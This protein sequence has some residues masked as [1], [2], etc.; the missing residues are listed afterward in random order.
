MIESIFL[1]DGRIIIE[2]NWAR[3]LDLGPIRIGLWSNRFAL[4]AVIYLALLAAALWVSFTTWKSLPVS[5]NH[6]IVGAMIGFRFMAVAFVLAIILSVAA[7][8]ALKHFVKN[9][10][11]GR[12]EWVCIFILLWRL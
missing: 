10:E 8:M 4:L 5:N 9:R 12:K 7:T 3:Q 11:E 1:N 6:T 2:K